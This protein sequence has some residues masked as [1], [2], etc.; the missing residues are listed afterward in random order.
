MTFLIDPFDC[1]QGDKK[2]DT[3]LH[4]YDKDEISDCRLMIDVPIVRGKILTG[5]Y[6]LYHYFRCMSINNC[7]TRLL[8]ILGRVNRNGAC[9][10]LSKSVHISSRILSPTTSI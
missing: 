5:D 2:L 1:A 6:K 10:A 4:R 3:R 8:A 7:L 9:L